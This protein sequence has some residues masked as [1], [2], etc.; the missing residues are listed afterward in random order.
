MFGK[1]E[2]TRFS[3]GN[4]HQCFSI[5]RISIVSVTPKKAEMA[6]FWKIGRILYLSYLLYESGDPNFFFYF[7]Y[8]YIVKFNP[9]KFEEIFISRTMQLLMN[10][11]NCNYDL[12]M[13]ISSSHLHSIAYSVFIGQKM[14]FSGQD[15]QNEHA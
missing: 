5:R 13:A 15:L 1:M 6:P 12:N 8:V 14:Q 7:Y 9:G 4:A 11:L 3:Q 10:Y 2:K